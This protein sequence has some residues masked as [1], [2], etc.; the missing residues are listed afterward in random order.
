MGF[1]KHRAGDILIGIA[2]KDIKADEIIKIEIRG[3]GYFFSDEIDFSIHNIRITH[4]MNMHNKPFHKE[5][6]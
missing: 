3:P 6:K 1:R 2:Q 5:K 4:E